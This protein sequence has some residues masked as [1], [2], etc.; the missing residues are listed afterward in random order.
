MQRKEALMYQYVSFVTIYLKYWNSTKNKEYVNV[1]RLN[2]SAWL[3]FIVKLEIRDIW[4]CLSH[5]YQD[6]NDRYS[7]LNASRNNWYVFL[8]AIYLF[9]PYLEIVSTYT[10]ATF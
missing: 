8:P 4:D 5:G 1:V 6:H 9:W 2:S 10:T 7:Y 3:F